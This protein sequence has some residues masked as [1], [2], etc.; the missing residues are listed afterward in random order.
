M[1]AAWNK[2][3]TMGM[4]G[5]G[6]KLCPQFVHDFKGFAEVDDVNKVLVMLTNKLKMDL[7]K[8][9]VL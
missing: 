4:N 9:F 8:D 5:V 6:N 3:L 1:K 7:E 2:T